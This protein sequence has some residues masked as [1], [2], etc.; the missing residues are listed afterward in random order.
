VNRESPKNQVNETIVGMDI[1]WEDIINEA[2]RII[3]F[4]PISYIESGKIKN[5]SMTMPYA[6]LRLESPVIPHEFMM[7]VVHK[8]DFRHLWHI[9]KE[10][11][12]NEKEEVLVFC[13]PKRF[14]GR[15]QA[16][17]HIYIYPLGYY[18]EVSDPDFKPDYI[19]ERFIPI[20]S[21]KPE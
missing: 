8:V 12:V 11:E 15:F 10:R 13:V 21:W 14:L 4:L 7:P 17:L 16:R 1:P 6:M 5:S 3:K 9:F 18:Q 20:A 19:E 2:C